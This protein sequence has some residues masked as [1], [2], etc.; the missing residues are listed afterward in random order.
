MENN[1]DENV[2]SRKNTFFC[3]EID[4]FG[5]KAIRMTC[6]VPDIMRDVRA[7]FTTLLLLYLNV[8]WAGL[9]ANIGGIE[10]LYPLTA[11]FDVGVHGNLIDPK[12][13]EKVTSFEETIQYGVKLEKG[14]EVQLGYRF[15]VIL[16]K[17]TQRWILGS[18]E[19][20]IQLGN[21]HGIHL[22]LLFEKHKQG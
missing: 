14:E 21:E 12:T 15:S 22:R 4:F 11:G 19:I 1:N 5:T 6:T 2:D 20:T 13:S 3:E 9:V 7:H 10:A 16:N 8:K 18:D 17:E